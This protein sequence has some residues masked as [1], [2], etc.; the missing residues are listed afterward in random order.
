[1]TGCCQV[2]PSKRRQLRSRHEG[3]GTPAWRAELLFDGCGFPAVHMGVD[4]AT[5]GRR[6][7]ALEKSLNARLFDRQHTGC[8]LT[9]AGER[10]LQTAEELESQILRVQG[11]L[12]RSDVEIGGV[13]RIAAPDGFGTL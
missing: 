2:G 7:N 9:P 12:S 11:D 6:I 3:R 10:F 8:I 1:M 5:V 4:T 13:V